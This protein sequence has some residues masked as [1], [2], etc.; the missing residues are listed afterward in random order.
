MVD[1]IFVKTNTVMSDEE[2]AKRKKQLEEESGTKVV[3]L[4]HTEEVLFK[5]NIDKKDRW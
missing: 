2:I 5:L 1:V 3:M 4:K